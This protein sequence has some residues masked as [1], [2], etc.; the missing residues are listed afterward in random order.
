MKVIS[1][2]YFYIIIFSN[3]I[4]R[5]EYL[6]KINSDPKFEHQSMTQ[7]GCQY[8][9]Q[10]LNFDNFLDIMSTS[11][12]GAGNLINIYNMFLFTDINVV[13]INVMLGCLGC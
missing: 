12:T 11:M 13:V 3:N 1:I 5:R 9:F 10:H 2:S 6:K 8:D 4:S 7:L